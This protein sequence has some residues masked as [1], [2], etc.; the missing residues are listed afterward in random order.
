VVGNWLIRVNTS[1]GSPEIT[2]AVSKRRQGSNTI[3]SLAW[4]STGSGSVDVLRNRTVIATTDDDGSAQDHI[5][6]QTGSFVYQVCVTG[7]SNC[8]NE[9]LVRV[10]P[11]SD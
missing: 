1:S 8:S 11:H 7:S 3:M 6:S 10:R 5:G 9:V 4:N 2:L